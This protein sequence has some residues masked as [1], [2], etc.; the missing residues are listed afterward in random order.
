[1]AL[2]KF[3]QGKTLKTRSDRP[4]DPPLEGPGGRGKN[5]QRRFRDVH[6]RVYDPASPGRGAARWARIKRQREEVRHTNHEVERLAR[7]LYDA[8]RRGTGHYTAFQHLD[9]RRTISGL[10]SPKEM[11]WQTAIEA[12]RAERTTNFE[13]RSVRP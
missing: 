3:L 13:R 7:R 4:G 9:H 5:R 6:G 8:Y 10:I 11:W 12:L 2:P 1:M